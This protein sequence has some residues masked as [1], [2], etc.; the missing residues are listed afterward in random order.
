MCT[1]TNVRT[2]PY[3]SSSAVCHWLQRSADI[4][5]DVALEGTAPFHIRVGVDMTAVSRIARLVT[6]Y[7]ESREKLFTTRR[8]SP[9]A[10]PSAVVMSISRRASPPRRQC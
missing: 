2:D 1:Q 4:I 9:T 3:F 8:A 7:P 6:L 5:T 10:A